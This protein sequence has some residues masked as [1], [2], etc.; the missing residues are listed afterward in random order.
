MFYVV[1]C[2]DIN[3]T[4]SPKMLSGR[5]AVEQLKISL[6]EAFNEMNQRDFAGIIATMEHAFT[7]EDRANADPV[8]SAGQFIVFPGFDAVG[9]AKA[10]KAHVSE[11]QF[12]TD[13]G[14]TPLFHAAAHDGFKV[15]V[16]ADLKYRR[17]FFQQLTEC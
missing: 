11:N 13:P 9:K 16:E 4:K 3:A 15:M 8:E 1:R 6:A 7:E 2:G 17:L 10:M 12:F 5:L 14:I